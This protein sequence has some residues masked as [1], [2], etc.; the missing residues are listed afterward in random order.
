MIEAHTSLTTKIPTPKKIKKKQ[1]G[2]LTRNVYMKI[3]QSA[4]VTH[5]LTFNFLFTVVLEICK[6]AVY[7]RLRASAPHGLTD[8]W[9]LMITAA[10]VGVLKEGI[11]CFDGH[12]KSLARALSYIITTL[13]AIACLLTIVSQMLAVEHPISRH[14]KGYYDFVELRAARALR[15]LHRELIAYWVDWAIKTVMAI[16]AHLK[17]KVEKA[18]KVVQAVEKEKKALLASRL[19]YEYSSIVDSTIFIDNDLNEEEQMKLRTMIYEMGGNATFKWSRMG[20]DTYVDGGNGRYREVALL[21]NGRPM[22]SVEWVT[23]IGMF[24][25]AS[26]LL[27]RLHLRRHERTNVISVDPEPETQMSDC[28]EFEHISFEQD[29]GSSQPQASTS[30]TAPEQ[31]LA[32]TGEEVIERHEETEIIA[33]NSEPEFQVSDCDGFDYISF[34][35]DCGSTEPQAAEPPTVHQQLLA[36]TGEELTVCKRNLNLIIHLATKHLWKN[37]YFDNDTTFPHCTRPD[38]NKK[39]TAFL[40]TLSQKDVRLSLFTDWLEALEKSTKQGNNSTLVAWLSEQNMSDDELYQAVGRWRDTTSIRK[41]FY[42]LFG[43]C[44]DISSLDNQS[45]CSCRR[46]GNRN[47]GY[48]TVTVLSRLVSWAEERGGPEGGGDI[49]SVGK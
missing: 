9:Y 21:M 8:V 46:T 44:T 45:R 38:S 32:I 23:A 5:Y 20:W 10:A 18:R 17:A 7:F 33:M 31:L 40:A 42:E 39:S 37:G 30:L 36:I 35:K 16:L 19:A 11:S 28:E 27:V 34:E 47:H 2:F 3:A 43:K 29:C 1:P 6:H 22:Q 14:P 26:D 15:V 24:N 48:C 41:E 25:Y 13:M 12:S 49:D 4:Y